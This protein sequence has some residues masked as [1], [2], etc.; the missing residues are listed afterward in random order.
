MRYDSRQSHKL[1]RESC[2][3]DATAS[4]PLLAYSTCS[5]IIIAS[6]SLSSRGGAE[7]SSEY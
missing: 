1:E 5:I 4:R 2:L 6:L 7:D 3:W